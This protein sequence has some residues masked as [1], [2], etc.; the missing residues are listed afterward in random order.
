MSFVSVAARSLHGSLYLQSK[1]PLAEAS[2]IHVFI[3]C[4]LQHTPARIP[5]IARVPDLFPIA[6][7]VYKSQVAQEPKTSTRFLHLPEFAVA[8]GQTQILHL[9]RLHAL[10]ENEE[11]R[12]SKKPSTCLP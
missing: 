11:E 1:S 2:V 6:A 8:L 7:Y 12:K 4:T 3:T 10:L 5:G 9:E